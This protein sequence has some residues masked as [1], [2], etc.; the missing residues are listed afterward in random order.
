MDIKTKLGG[1]ISSFKLLDT[2][3]NLNYFFGGRIDFLMVLRAIYP[4]LRIFLHVQII[5]YI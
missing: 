1:Y 5:N 3:L 2:Y 4:G